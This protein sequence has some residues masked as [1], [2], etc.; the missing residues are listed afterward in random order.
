MPFDLRE[1]P[2]VEQINADRTHLEG[3]W[4]GA[5]AEMQRADEIYNGT[6]NIWTWF[7]TPGHSVPEAVATRPQFHSARGYAL[8][9]HA[10]D[11]NMSLYPKWHREPVRAGKEHEERADRIE[12]ALSAITRDAFLRSYQHPSKVTGQHLIMY[13]YAALFV[14]LDD[15]LLLEQPRRKR[16]ED[17][18]D[19]E[20]REWEW[21]SS[22][23][24]WNPIKLEAVTPG[25]VLMDPFRKMPDLAIRRRKLFA[26]ELADL[27]TTKARKLGNEVEIYEIASDPYE[28]VEPTERWTAFWYVIMAPSGKILWAEPNTWGFMPFMQ[29]WAGDVTGLVGQDLKPEDLVRQSMVRQESDNIVMHDQSYAA[30]HQIIQRAAFAKTI[31]DG[32]ASDAA[33][34]MEGDIIPGT[35][36]EWGV[37][38][39]PNLAPQS[40]T[41]QENLRKQIEETSYSLTMAGITD[42]GLDTATQAIMQSEASNRKIAAVREQM[43]H[44]YSIAGSNMLRLGVRLP[45]ELPDLDSISIGK[46]KLDPKDIAGNFRIEASFEA[47]D[48]VV[49]AQEKQAAREELRDKLISRAHY[50]RIA[51]HENASEMEK[52]IIKDILRELPGVQAELVEAALREEGFGKLAD[53]QERQRRLADL[54]GPDGQPLLPPA[55]GNGNGRA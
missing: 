12:K 38:K 31:Y 52:E 55:G 13:N 39:V 54:V 34:K 49:F 20:V 28:Q 10:V 25:T 27:T 22:R 26:Y 40:M 15:R 24:G 30:N 5:L 18:E 45:Q 48:P 8:V 43:N 32:D 23:N 9:K 11:A 53:E 7:E 19:F 4:T 6:Y 14:G 47:V 51:R 35:E 21:E 36:A 2:T 16:G 33:K 17:K 29:T 3:V 44:I 41:H 1:R 42:T 50:H 37:E 46:D